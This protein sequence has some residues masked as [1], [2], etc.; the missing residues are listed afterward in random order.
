MAEITTSD[1]LKQVHPFENY[2]P[3][4]VA[5][6]W[7]NGVNEGESLD[8]GEAA[9]RRFDERVT[10][11]TTRHEYSEHRPNQ[12]VVSIGRRIEK[13]LETPGTLAEGANDALR[14]LSHVETGMNPAM[15]SYLGNPQGTPQEY[16]RDF[17]GLKEGETSDNLGGE[18]RRAWDIDSEVAAAYLG[19]TSTLGDEGLTLKEAREAIGATVG[20]LVDYLVTD[21]EAVAA[22]NEKHAS[23]AVKADLADNKDA[24]ITRAK[25]LAESKGHTITLKEAEE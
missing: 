3:P 8:V 16:M 6:H 7:A 10:G 9:R 4:H 2:V 21:S 13:T 14:L 19:I 24:Y 12:Q 23:K 15:S 5:E 25:E 18:D 11:L 20:D 22:H 17:Y 1:V